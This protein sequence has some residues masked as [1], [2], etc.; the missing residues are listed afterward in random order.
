MALCTK[1]PIPFVGDAGRSV[2]SGEILPCVGDMANPRAAPIASPPS[3]D[4]ASDGGANFCVSSTGKGDLAFAIG[5]ASPPDTEVFVEKRLL[6]A[7]LLR[8]EPKCEGELERML[9]GGGLAASGSAV[10]SRDMPGSCRFPD[11]DPASEALS[12][13]FRRYAAEPMPRSGV[14]LNHEGSLAP[15]D[16]AIWFRESV[17]AAGEEGS[18]LRSRG[19]LAA[20]LSEATETADRGLRM[21]PVPD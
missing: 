13:W 19:E 18:G 20:T 4:E 21:L 2:R 6:S 16:C 17:G 11:T 3:V 1:P 15:R 9:S 12:S 8:T 14:C 5:S 7:V 10:D